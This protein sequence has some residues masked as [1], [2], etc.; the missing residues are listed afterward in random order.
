MYAQK[1]GAD[2]KM[3]FRI[4]DRVPQI[5]KSYESGLNNLRDIC[6]TGSGKYGLVGAFSCG[7]Y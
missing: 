2:L 5:G 3:F 4:I 1:R 7:T 6:G